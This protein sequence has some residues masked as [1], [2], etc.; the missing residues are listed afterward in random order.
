ME[1]PMIKEG[2][3]GKRVLYIEDTFDNRILIKRVLEASGY[4]VDE[5]PDGLTGIQIAA[6]NR[7]DLVL[8]DINLPDIDGYEVTARLRQM[9]GFEKIPI[10]ALT[11]NV[12]DGDRERSLDSGCD[13]Y[14]PKPVDVDELPDQI[15]AFL[16]G[17][18]RS[19]QSAAA[20]G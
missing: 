12:L 6:Q 18:S 3:N 8:M 19:A 14:I 9:E 1:N 16:D 20:A 10:V 7:P 4:I 13:G 11:A 2:V 15:A 17:A 5:A